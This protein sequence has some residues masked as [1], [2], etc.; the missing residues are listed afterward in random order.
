MKRLITT[1]APTQIGHYSCSYFLLVLDDS[2][3]ARLDGI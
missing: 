1:A 3:L 2:V